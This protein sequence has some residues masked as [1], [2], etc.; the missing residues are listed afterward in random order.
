M[1]H[2]RPAP[3]L[4][5]D[6]TRS[7]AHSGAYFISDLHLSDD[8]P[9]TLTQFEYFCQ[10]IAVTQ[11]ALFILGDLFEFWIGDD[12]CTVSTAAQRVIQSLR[13]LNQRGTTVYFIAGNR[14]FLLQSDYCEQAGMIALPD[15]CIVSINQQR[16]L[17]TH[18]DLLCTEDTDYQ[19]YRRFV[20]K[21]WV[22]RLFLKSPYSWR[23]KLAERLRNNSKA[24]K[25]KTY[26]HAQ[27][28]KQ[29]VVEAST[30]LWFDKNTT[31]LIIHGH[32]H[33]PKIHL[34]PYG[35]RCVLP[36]WDCEQINHIRWGYALIDSKQHEPTLSLIHELKNFEQ[37][38]THTHP[39]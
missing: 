39:I 15:P 30:Q 19:R 35:L 23:L 5:I 28:I 13:T 14:D 17:I 33:R 2:H 6:L 26:T 10:H 18:G 16:T 1:P 27:Y 4:C 9:A 21:K 32:T 36:D 8:L 3:P 12:V 7:V 31:Q 25:T 22:Q 20:H 24:H 29:D 34:Q 37:I 11:P 38:K